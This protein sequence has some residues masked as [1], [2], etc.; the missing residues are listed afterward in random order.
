MNSSIKNGI[1]LILMISLIVYIF[2]LNIKNKINICNIGICD[3]MYNLVM[4]ELI[5][6][7]ELMML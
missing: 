2:S 7:M 4:I 1:L 5:V 6:C 3:K